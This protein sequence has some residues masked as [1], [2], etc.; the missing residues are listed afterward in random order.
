MGRALFS[1]EVG[2]LGG[3]LGW[4]S[5]GVGPGILRGSLAWVFA[6]GRGWELGETLGSASDLPGTLVLR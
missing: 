1:L 6:W 4:G 3:A 5:T 2:T